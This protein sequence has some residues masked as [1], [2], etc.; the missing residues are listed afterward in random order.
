M[1]PLPSRNN[2][3]FTYRQLVWV[4]TPIVVNVAFVIGKVWDGQPLIYTRLG[5]IVAVLLLLWQITVY[6][7]GG[8]FFAWLMCKVLGISRE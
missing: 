4:V 1:S 8:V 5:P 7:F 3:L 6:Y 2:P